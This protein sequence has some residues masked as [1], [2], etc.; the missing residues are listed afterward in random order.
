[1]ISPLTAAVTLG[2]G[3]LAIVCAITGQVALLECARKVSPQAPPIR[4]WQYWLAAILNTASIFCMAS[5]IAVV[6]SDNLVATELFL[7]LATMVGP[8][9]TAMKLYKQVQRQR[10]LDDGG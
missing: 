10:Q 4:Q 1:M 8:V 3:A 9:I 6:M 2:L 7:L 5:I